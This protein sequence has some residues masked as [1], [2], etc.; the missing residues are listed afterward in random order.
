MRFDT[1]FVQVVL[2]DS[3]H[4]LRTLGFEYID[5]FCYETARVVDD[6]SNATEGLCMNNGSVFRYD[7]AKTPGCDARG[8]R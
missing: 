5:A 2:T 4:A 7:L 3:C 8:F 6:L 1:G